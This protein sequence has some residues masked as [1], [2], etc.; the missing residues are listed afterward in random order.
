MRSAGLR[1][2]AMAMG[3]TLAAL[4]LTVTSLAGC[5]GQASQTS[6]TSQPSKTS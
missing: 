6:N 5:T 3:I 1:G 2:R 4:S